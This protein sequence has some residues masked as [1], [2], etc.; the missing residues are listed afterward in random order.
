M[1]SSRSMY[2]SRENGTLRVPADAILRVVDDVD[3]LDLP[4]GIVGDH[5]LERP[6]HRHHARRAA[7]QILA[8]A[9]L[10]LRDVDDVFLLRH[11]DPRAEVADRLR[12]CSRGGA[13]R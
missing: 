2:S 6:Q 5:D 11:A 1:K 8:H 7:V 9:V 4:F 13:G 12:A 10:E 3:L